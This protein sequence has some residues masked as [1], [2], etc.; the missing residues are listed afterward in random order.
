MEYELSL[1]FLKDYILLLIRNILHE[2]NVSL[3]NDIA[4]MR[5]G[6]CHI[7]PKLQRTY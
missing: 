3:E 5:V 1:K 2:V 6:I 4:S 7:I